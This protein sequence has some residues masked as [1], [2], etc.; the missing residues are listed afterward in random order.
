MKVGYKNAFCI[1]LKAKWNK[2]E[3]ERK[4]EYLS[5]ALFAGSNL[6]GNMYS[7]KVQG[8]KIKIKNGALVPF[9]NLFVIVIKL[10][11]LS[12]QSSVFFLT[13]K[14]LVTIDKSVQI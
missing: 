1:Q 7:T 6:G 9:W 3:S 10:K 4:V 12:F 8:N 5:V 13:K 11:S 14:L 2:E